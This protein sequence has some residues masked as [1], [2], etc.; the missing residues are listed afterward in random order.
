M[1]LA[2]MLPGKSEIHL[3]HLVAVYDNRQRVVTIDFLGDRQD[4]RKERGGAKE[5]EDI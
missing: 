5:G 4:R 1:V 3:L 2:M